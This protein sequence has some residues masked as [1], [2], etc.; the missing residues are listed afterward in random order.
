MKYSKKIDYLLVLIGCI[1]AIYAQVDEQQNVFILGVGIVLL[2]FGLFKISLTI[3]SKKNKN[4]DS[5]I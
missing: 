5:N 3:T 1:V 4:E 2:M